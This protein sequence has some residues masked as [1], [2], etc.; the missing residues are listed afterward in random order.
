MISSF[1][2]AAL[3][4][5]AL[6]MILLS[7]PA[8]IAHE[9]RPAIAEVEFQ[10]NYFLITFEVNLE[11]ILAEI[12]PGHEDTDESANANIYNQYRELEP[13]ELDSVFRKQADKFLRKLTV[14]VNDQ[15]TESHLS[16]VVVSEVGDIELPRDS[17]VTVGGSLPPGSTDFIFGWDASLGPI[18]IR[19]KD[20]QENGYSAYLLDGQTS[21]SIPTTGAAPKQSAWSVF[22]NY[23][24]VGFEHIV[25][26][27]LDHILF[28]VGL[29][30]L[31]ATIRP[32]V[33]Q[34]TC[35]TLAHT[36][37]LALGLFGVLT[38]PASVVEPLIAISIVYVAVE[39]ILF[40]G[41]TKWRPVLVFAFGLLHGLGFAGVLSEFG[42]PKGNYVAGLLGFNLGVEFGQL[43]VIA[44]C[45]ATVGFWFGNKPW[46]RKAVIIPGSLA[47]A[48]MGMY[49]VIERTLL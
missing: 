19:T 45:F 6:L 27:G 31:S 3:I 22:A 14:L 44:V 16:S 28:V 2:A 35:F 20:N 5:Q 40:R 11:A 8:A 43:A 18:V 49:W 38:V 46:Y 1:R 23:I 36:L 12:G 30:L 42:L 37:T 9:M 32:L 13:V 17:A 39:N 47:I 41:M 25:P 10:P 24:A 21:D 33:T 34:I 29:F 26:L 4:C 7:A 48:A 15:D